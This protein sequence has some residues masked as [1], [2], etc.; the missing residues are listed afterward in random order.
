MGLLLRV[1]AALGVLDEARSALEIL[2]SREHPDAAEA[3]ASYA[4]PEDRSVVIPS[5]G[6]H[7]ER[8]L[9]WLAALGPAAAIFRPGHASPLFS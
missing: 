8:P 5:T 1:G 3:A 6:P 2:L 9:D 7:S 4:Y